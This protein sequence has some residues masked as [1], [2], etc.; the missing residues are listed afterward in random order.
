[1]S[2]S[3]RRA[4]LSITIDSALLDAV[5]QSMQERGITNRSVVIDEAL[6]LWLAREQERAIEAQH[7][8]PQSAE[9]AAEYDSW[10][11]IRDHAARRLFRQR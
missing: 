3:K 11:A 7:T 9:E 1:M 6:R 4:K 5:A 2:A 10:R 8:A